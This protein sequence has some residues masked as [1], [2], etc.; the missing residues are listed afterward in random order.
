MIVTQLVK[1]EALSSYKRDNHSRAEPCEVRKTRQDQ[2][3]P[4]LRL[5]PHSPCKA[6]G[7][8][9]QHSLHKLINQ[10]ARYPIIPLFFARQKKD[11]QLRLNLDGNTTSNLYFPTMRWREKPTSKHTNFTHDA[12]KKETSNKHI[13]SIHDASKKETSS[14]HTNPIHELARKKHPASIP[15][16]FMSW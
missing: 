4:T 15:I 16:S 7:K 8:H 3:D 11:Q 13:D 12:S 1:E 6:A 5:C 2:L 14:K 10:P 9:Y